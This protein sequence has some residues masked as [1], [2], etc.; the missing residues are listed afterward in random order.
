MPLIRAGNVLEKGYDIV[1]AERADLLIQLRDSIYRK[2][3]DLAGS[4][5]HE[6]EAFLNGFH[7]LGFEGG[8]LNELRLQMVEHCTGIAAGRTV[9]EI[10]DKH[11]TA[12]LGPDVV[13]QKTV[14]LVIQQPGDPDQVPTHRDAPVN[15]P[16]EVVVWLPLVD[17]FRTKGMYI[18]DRPSSFEAARFLYEPEPSYEQYCTFAEG[19]GSDLTV[20]FG[21]AC[22]FWTGLVHGCRINAENETR[23]SLNIRYKNLFSPYGSKGLGDYFEIL[24]L[25]P[26]ARAAF[27]FEKRSLVH[28]KPS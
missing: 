1:P 11:L 20:P 5:P 25:S 13:S 21:D 17:C 26:L 14:N 15:S 7:T 8:R 2:A 16:F 23:W 27:E 6:P 9:F 10:F 3:R 4:G 28:E 22:V 19:H 12:L 18:L 24:R